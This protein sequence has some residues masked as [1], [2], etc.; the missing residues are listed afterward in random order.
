M[1]MRTKRQHRNTGYDGVTNGTLRSK[2]QLLL[3]QQQ[4]HAHR[5]AGCCC[6]GAGLLGGRIVAWC[7][8]QKKGNVRVPMYPLAEKP[9]LHPIITCVHGDRGFGNP[10]PGNDAETRGFV[11]SVPNAK[12]FFKACHARHTAWIAPKPPAT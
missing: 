6:W 1:E 8:V 11:L 5:V 12:H 9:G 4:P 2:N 7:S 3:V 10:I